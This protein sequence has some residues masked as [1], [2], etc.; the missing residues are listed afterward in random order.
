[1][2]SSFT[3]SSRKP[4]HV[5]KVNASSLVLKDSSQAKNTN[6][7]KL[8]MFNWYTLPKMQK[9]FF[10]Y[11]ITESKLCN[12]M[13]RFFILPGGILS[14]KIWCAINCNCCETKNRNMPRLDI[15]KSNIGISTSKRGSQNMLFL[16]L[17]S[18]FDFACWKTVTKRLFC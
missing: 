10:V 15:V 11:L 1:M 16:N 6:G 18:A 5:S 8:Y 3:I 12:N 17:L 13:H 2:N 9:K 14:G 7:I 4:T